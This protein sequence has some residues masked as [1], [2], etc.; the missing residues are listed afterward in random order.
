[1]TRFLHTHM[2][3]PCM[4]VCVYVCVGLRC[5]C[6]KGSYTI[7]PNDTID[8]HRGDSTE[9]V[10]HGEGDSDTGN[11][12]KREHVTLPNHS[13]EIHTMREGDARE[14]NTRKARYESTQNRETAYVNT[15][16]RE[17]RNESTQN[18]EVRSKNTR[19]ARH[20]NTHHGEG[21]HTHWGGYTSWRHAP[22]RC[23]EE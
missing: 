13:A 19:K 23:S 1:M 10:V 17:P 16:N 8:I 15:H 2:L 18:R 3:P 7:I 11:T 5:H 22:R 20:V 12:L 4:C 14:E 9:R 6:D 21:E